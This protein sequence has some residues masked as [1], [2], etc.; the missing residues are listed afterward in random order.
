[1]KYNM[2][3]TKV[4]GLAVAATL[5]FG[6]CSDDWDEHYDVQQI[7]NGGTLWE[8]IAGD[9]NLSNFAMVLDS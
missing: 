7:G 8:A 3:Y 1:M 4:L 6:A 9:E 5:A 2:K